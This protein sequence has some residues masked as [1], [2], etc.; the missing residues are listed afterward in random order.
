MQMRE[1]EKVAAYVL[2]VQ[3]PVHLMKECGET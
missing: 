2:K 1:D 3:N